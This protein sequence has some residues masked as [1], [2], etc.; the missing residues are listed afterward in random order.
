MKNYANKGKLL[1]EA[2]EEIRLRILAERRGALYEELL[3]SLEGQGKPV[4]HDEKL[5]RLK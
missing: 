5:D 2:W 3:R 4:I 1:E